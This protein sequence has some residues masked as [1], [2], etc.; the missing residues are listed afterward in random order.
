MLSDLSE[1]AIYGRLK[2]DSIFTSVPMAACYRLAT[3][4]DFFVLSSIIVWKA[5]SFDYLPLR[6]LNWK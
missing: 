1:A 3:E 6:L 4:L 2:C 5:F